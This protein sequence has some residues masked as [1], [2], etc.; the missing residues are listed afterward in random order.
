MQSTRINQE[1]E[2]KNTRKIF[3]PLYI[4]KNYEFEP[5][6]NSNDLISESSDFLLTI[7]N[8]ITFIP[9]EV[10]KV[11]DLQIRVV[12]R[13]S[14]DILAF[15]TITNTTFVSVLDTKTVA[16]DAY[17]YDKDASDSM[18]HLFLLRK[19]FSQSG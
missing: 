19:N 13:G 11:F 3:R 17:A 10:D 4:D 1:N 18:G 2:L 14:A 8:S 9:L 15:L 6:I 12:N 16:F 5:V 7:E